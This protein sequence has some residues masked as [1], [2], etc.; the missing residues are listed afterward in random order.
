GGA[1]AALAG[2]SAHPS[3]PLRGAAFAIACAFACATIAV[4][5]EP[6]EPELLRRWLPAGGAPRWGAR[7]LVLMGWLQ[8]CV[9]LLV[10]AVTIRHGVGA[11]LTVLGLV[12]GGALLAALLAVACSRLKDRGIAVYGPVAP[13]AAAAGAAWLLQGGG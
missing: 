12:E 11:G 5:L 13:V 2:W 1:A 9:W 4:L 10:A 3:A 7:L 8:G 6:D